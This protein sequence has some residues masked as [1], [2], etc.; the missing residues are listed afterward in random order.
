VVDALRPEFRDEVAFVLANLH[1]REGREFAARHGVPNTT[2]VFLDAGGRRLAILHG[3]QED[4][5]LR[6]QILTILGLPAS[7]G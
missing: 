6:R 7:T 1:T 5:A 2:L 4:A 3:T